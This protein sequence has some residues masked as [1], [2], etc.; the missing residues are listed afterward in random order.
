LNHASTSFYQ[1]LDVAQRFFVEPRAVFTRSWED[2]FLNNERLARYRFSDL[3][4]M[5]DLGVN[6]GDDAQLR[7]GYL[8]TQRKA[9]VETGSLILP[10]AG[11]NDAG[12]QAVATFDSRDT[13]FNPTRGVAAALEYFYSDDALG[14]ALDWQRIEAGVGVAVPTRKDV[15][16]IT[17]AGGSDLG[18][19]VPRD[20][21]FMLGGPGSFPGYELGELRVEEYWTLSGSYLRKIKDIMSIRGQALYVGLRLEAGQ[22]FGRLEE[23]VPPELVPPG[24]DAGEVIYGGSLYLAGRTMAGPLTVGLGATS[25]D[26]WSLWIAVGRPVGHGTILEKGIFR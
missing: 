20:R 16:W 15:V 9:E 7:V 3:G 6:L 25:T 5:I 14:A 23:R 11:R 10:E 12:L 13:P 2:V 8:Y 22:T 21:L 24:F 19:G 18:T 4:G 26:S 17:L 1:P